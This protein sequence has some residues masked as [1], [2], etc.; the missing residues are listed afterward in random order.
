MILENNTILIT[1]GSSG[2]G[3]EMARKLSQR[4]NKVLICGRTKAKLEEAKRSNPKI[5]IFQCDLAK[6]EECKKLA[7]WIMNEHPECNILINN[8]AIVH[9]TNFYNDQDAILKA[10]K[11]IYTN[12]IAPLMLVKTLIPVLEKNSNP[13]II[14]ITTGLVYIPKA[15]YSFYNSTKAALHS[16]TQ[17]LRL[18]LEKSPIKIIEVMYPAVDTPWHNGNPPGI[19]IK[20]EIAVQEAISGIEKG[21]TEI[22]VGKVKLIYNISRIAPSHAFR[23]INQ[24]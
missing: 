3:L 1:G 5:Q 16:F 14:N 12:F 15:A 4:N 19:A 22:K 17:V 18:Q 23:K 2:I 10:E 9:R 8:A 7:H 13:K 6:L 21:K 11:E 20:P 24:T